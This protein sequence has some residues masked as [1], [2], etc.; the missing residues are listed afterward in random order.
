MLSH[1]RARSDY[2]TT[3]TTL[4]AEPIV[5]GSMPIRGSHVKE[6]RNAIDAVRICAG[7]PPYAPASGEGWTGWPASYSNQTGPILA[8]HVGAMRRALDEA[9]AQLNGSHLATIANP[10]G[11]ILAVHFNDLREAVR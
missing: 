8:V 4:F 1:R 6:L 5:G 11:T 3:A 2:A 10:S 9:I 7:L